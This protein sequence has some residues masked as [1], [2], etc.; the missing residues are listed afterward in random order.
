MI[1]RRL[2]SFL[3]AAMLLLG[4]GNASAGL[5]DFIQTSDTGTVKTFDVMLDSMGYTVGAVDTFYDY[6]NPAAIVSTTGLSCM[7]SGEGMPGACFFNMGYSWTDASVI[8]GALADVAIGGYQTAAP[9]A[10]A[11]LIYRLTVAYT[12]SAGPANLV[13]NFSGPFSQVIDGTSVPI[14]GVIQAVVT[15][16]PEPGTMT[17]LGL[18]LAG[19]AFLRRR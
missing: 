12:T 4:A 10:A 13:A 14:P 1:S 15:I 17:L 2:F 5:I 11:T 7:G 19:L 16:V 9:A 3:A 6:D 18:G 8:G